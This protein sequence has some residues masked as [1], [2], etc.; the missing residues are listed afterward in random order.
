MSSR[1][2]IPA[3]KPE[4]TKTLGEYL[5]EFKLAQQVDN[6]RRGSNKTSELDIYIEKFG[7]TS[8]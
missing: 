6:K 7:I 8:E 2:I 4:K 3:K 1:Q 5:R